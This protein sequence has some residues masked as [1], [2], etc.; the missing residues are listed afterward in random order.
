MTTDPLWQRLLVAATGPAITA[1]LALFVVNL[2]AKGAEKRKDTG[3]TR[4]RLAAEMTLAANSLY[5]ALQEFWRTR[6]AARLKSI[7]TASERLASR[8]RL[9]QVYSTAR[10][11]GQVLEQRLA[12]FFAAKDP[13]EQWHQVMDL[14]TVRSFMLTEEDENKRRRIREISAGESLSRLSAKDLRNPKLLLE[15][16]RNALDSAIVSLWKYPVDRSGTHLTERSS[17][18][19]RHDEM[20]DAASGIVDGRSGTQHQHLSGTPWFSFLAVGAGFGSQAGW[21]WMTVRP[22]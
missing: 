17:I 12:I 1:I 20:A 14:L 2:I 13:K 5:L 21:Q 7:S 19:G 8:E 10:S 3:L 4:E 18:S 9:D 11:S 15:T 6:E 22:P 16:Y